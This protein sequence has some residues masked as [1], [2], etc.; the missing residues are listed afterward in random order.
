M[1]AVF[2]AALS[3]T[4]ESISCGGVGVDVIKILDKCFSRKV[5]LHNPLGV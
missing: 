2:L 1:I 5:G 3:R 4:L